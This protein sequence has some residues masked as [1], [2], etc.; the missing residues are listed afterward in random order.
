[1]LSSKLH[2]YLKL[3]FNEVIQAVIVF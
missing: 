1:M 3:I 2:D